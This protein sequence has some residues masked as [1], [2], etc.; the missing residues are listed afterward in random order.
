MTPRARP[1]GRTHWRRGALVALP[2]L[3]S[4]GGLAGAMTSG[5]LALDLRIQDR[6]LRLATSSVYGTQYG[7]AVV[8]V[9]HTRPD[10]TTGTVRVLRMGFADGVINGLCLS[11][12]QEIMGTTYTLLF[13]LGD[14]DPASWEIT[15]QNTVLDVREATGV[16]DM[17]G[18]VDL[19]VDGTDVTTV[20]DEAGNPVD[21]PL[22][23]PEHRFGI[24]A[25]YAKFDGITGT[26]QDIQIPGLLTTPRLDLSVRP[27]DVACPAPAPPVGTP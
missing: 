7:A 20:D 13:T 6:P 18:V 3:L 27:G 14:D 17:D 22:G 10:G 8:D 12:Q 26:V 11:Q 23:A 19:N 21:N 16:L 2:A 5:A 9:P 24:Q 15:T 1:E 25:G 4:A